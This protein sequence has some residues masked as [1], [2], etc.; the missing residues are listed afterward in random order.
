MLKEKFISEKING[1][2][3]YQGFTLLKLSDKWEEAHFFENKK[4]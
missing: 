3:N 2:F 1:T 4:P